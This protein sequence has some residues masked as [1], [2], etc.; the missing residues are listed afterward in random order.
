MFY[1][2]TVSFKGHRHFENVEKFEDSFRN[3]FTI[4]YFFRKLLEQKYIQTK[5]AKA[6]KSEYNIHSQ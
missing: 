5:C 1:F 4:F 3:K 2:Y 6:Q